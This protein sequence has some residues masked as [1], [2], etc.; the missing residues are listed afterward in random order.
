MNGT[1]GWITTPLTP[2]LVRGAAELGTTDRG[3]LP[4]RLPARAPAQVT[5]G[6]LAMAESQPSGVRIAV[7]TRATALELDTLPTKRVY[8]GG[9]PRPDGRYDLLVDGEPAGQAS[10]QGGSRL[11]IDMASGAA[12]HTPIRS[13]RGRCGTC[14]PI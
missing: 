8:M 14:R 10:V 11:N 1:G 9:P 4:H 5:D 12:E 6:Q 2:A 7:R 13:P 3:V